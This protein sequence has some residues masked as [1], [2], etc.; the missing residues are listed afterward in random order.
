[1]QSKLFIVLLCL[2]VVLSLM[3]QCD[4]FT[5]PIPG[6][7]EKVIQKV[8]FNS[9]K[10]GHRRTFNRDAVSEFDI[11]LSLSRHRRPSSKTSTSHRKHANEK[12]FNCCRTLAPFNVTNG[13]LEHP[14]AERKVTVY[15]S[16]WESVLSLSAM[17]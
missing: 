6:K 16:V 3:N 1:M 5:G 9:T 11:T 15:I 13:R 12:C 14:I 7:R 10:H 4:G 2:T 17:Q 8:S